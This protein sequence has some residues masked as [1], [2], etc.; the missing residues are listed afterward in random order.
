MATYRNIIKF[1]CRA[2]K[3]KGTAELSETDHSYNTDTHI[4]D[5]TAGFRVSNALYP[6]TADVYCVACDEKAKRID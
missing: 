5:V 1:K 3:A 6:D 4:N 2:C